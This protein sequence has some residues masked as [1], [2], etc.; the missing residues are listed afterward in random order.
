MGGAILTLT[1]GM[2]EPTYGPVLS[3]IASLWN[4]V[5]NKN[6]KL[7]AKKKKKSAELNK[8]F[9]CCTTGSVFCNVISGVARSLVLVGHLLYASRLRA[10]CARSRK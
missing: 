8:D 9:Q 3:L 10:L 6:P 7:Y 1:K 5:C 2:G 4:A